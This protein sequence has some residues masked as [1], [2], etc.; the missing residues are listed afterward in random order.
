MK[1]PARRAEK[2]EVTKVSSSRMKAARYDERTNLYLMSNLVA[3]T[4][5]ISKLGW[6]AK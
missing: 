5:K 6:T 4:E 1:K 2:H 3:A